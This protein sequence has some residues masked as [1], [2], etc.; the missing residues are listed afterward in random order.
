MEQAAEL[1]FC[2][3]V[4]LG[5]AGQNR[6]FCGLCG[7]GADRAPHPRPLGRPLTGL[8]DGL[9]PGLELGLLLQT[10]RRPPGEARNPTPP[11]SR[12]QP[13][14]ARGP[15][16]PS[17]AS[18]C[19]VWTT[20]TRSRQKVSSRRRRRKGALPGPVATE[21]RRSPGI[22]A[23]QSVRMIDAAEIPPSDSW[24]GLLLS[25][26]VTALASGLIAGLVAYLTVH[27]TQAGDRDAARLVASQA[28]ALVVQRLSLIHI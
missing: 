20:S 15:A 28:A 7:L 21:E 4:A 17:T 9:G 8:T 6:P 11:P 1:A 23:C 27:W 25:G 3:V 5:P 19:C 26:G 24:I 12:A 18:P 16:R 22:S 2:G 10:A 13:Q 14:T